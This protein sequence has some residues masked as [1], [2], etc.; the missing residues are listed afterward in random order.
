MNILV[1][2]ATRGIGKSIALGIDGNIFAVGRNEAL[3]KCYKNYFV[4]DLS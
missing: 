2:G 3:L 1:T 4:C